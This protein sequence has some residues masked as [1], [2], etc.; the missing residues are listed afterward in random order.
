MN[1]ASIDIGSNTVLLLIAEY[2]ET[3][4]E[5]KTILNRYRMPRISKGLKVTGIISEEKINALFEVL[6]EYQKEITKN[7]CERVILKATNAMRVANNSAEI[8]KAI[9]DKFDFDVEVVAG[10]E[11]ARLSFIG[12]SSAVENKENKTVIDIG[13]GSTEIIYGNDDKIIYRKSFEHGAVSLTE[14]FVDSYPMREEVVEKIGTELDELFA[15][16]KPQNFYTDI[17]VAV[18]GTPTTLSCMNLG[19]KNYSDEVIEGSLLSH[20]NLNQLIKTLKILLPNEIVN[21]YGQVVTGREDVILSGALILR[22]LLTILN[23]EKITV[24]SKGIRYGAL[25]DYV[26]K[27]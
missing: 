19:E 15:D 16:L 9:K 23:L 24:S 8:K 18:A 5:I 7:N 3:T 22:K 20:E 6:E 1:I 26:N 17:C 13:G 14:K 25:I 2:N 10:K 27:L 12:A 11:E 4:K 21:N